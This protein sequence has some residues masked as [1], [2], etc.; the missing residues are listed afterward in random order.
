MLGERPVYRFIENGRQATVFADTGER[1][2]ELT[3]EAALD[4]ARPFADA[5]TSAGIRIDDL[6]ADA[7]Q[8]TFSVRRD[9]PLYRISLDATGDGFVYVSARTGQAV[10]DTWS[11]ER[12]W[13]YIGAVMH[14]LYFTPFR[15]RAAV[16]AQSIIFLSAAGCL[17]SLSGLLWGLWR[18]SRAPRYRL[19]RVP[20]SSPYSGLMRWHHYAGLTFGLVTF[21]WV[22]SGLLSMD[23]FPWSPDTSLTAQ[24]RE[25]VTGGP[26]RLDSIT[27]DALRDGVDA[28]SL[29]SSS[30]PRELDVVQ[31]KGGLFLAA[32]DL[33][34]S[35]GVPTQRSHWIVEPNVG[36]PRVFDRFP[37]EAVV[38]AARAAMADTRIDALDWLH[39]Y[40]AYYYDREGER[41]L[42]VLRAQYADSK[43]TWLYFD[44]KS[45]AIVQKEERLSRV[46]RWLYHGLHSL[47]F[48][49]LYYRRPLWDLVVIALS[50]GGLVL[51]LTTMPVGWHRLRRHAR[52]WRRTPRPLTAGVAGRSAGNPDG[53]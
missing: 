8:W 43:R 32:E 1:L 36:N 23:P 12:R 30:G 44:P 34:G 49:F 48:P 17:L 40:D 28:F 45:G 21:T 51:S 38:E 19:K 29:R 6:L 7:D 41:P 5:D 37:D 47:D 50:A 42:P 53:R 25:A 46:N 24:Q 27:L 13:A 16:W 9:V 35:I 2:T 11:A 31:F 33:A 3:P 26:L 22:F 39:E 52:R 14:W 15:R 18:Y 20:S 4:V 10:M